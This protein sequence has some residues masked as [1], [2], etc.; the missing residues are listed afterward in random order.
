MKIT[1]KSSHWTIKMSDFIWFT[2]IIQKHLS[3]PFS[4]LPTSNIQP[5]HISIQSLSNCTLMFIYIFPLA[6]LHSHNFATHF[7]LLLRKW[8]GFILKSIC[9]PLKS[10]LNHLFQIDRSIQTCSNRL[11]YKPRE[12]HYM[13]QKKT[14]T[15][16]SSYLIC[17]QIK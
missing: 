4:P 1:G 11:F 3:S 17:I 7:H 10:P 8:C 6:S 15:T 12:F 14:A 5:D 2:C 13:R 16:L 9:L